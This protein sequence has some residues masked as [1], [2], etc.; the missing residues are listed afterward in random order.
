MDKEKAVIPSI[1]LI[2]SGLLTLGPSINT[3]AQIY[4]FDFGNDHYK[5]RN[6]RSGYINLTYEK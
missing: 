4:D 5:V 2:A 1:L 6:L 3:Q